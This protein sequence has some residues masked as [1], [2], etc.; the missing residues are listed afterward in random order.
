MPELPAPPV[1]PAPGAPIELVVC[2]GSACFARGNHGNV[3]I[4]REYL[5]ERGLEDR[6]NLTGT[7]CQNQCRQGPNLQVDGKCVSGVDPD[8]LPAIL[9]E[10]LKP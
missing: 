1:P 4:I 2:M 7:L 5:R 9:D 3:E 8:T 6:V 10:L